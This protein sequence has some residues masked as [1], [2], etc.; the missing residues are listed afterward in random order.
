M[1]ATV[2]NKALYEEIMEKA[3]RIGEVA[4]IEALEAD[5]NSTISQR[6]AD[7]IRDENIHRLILPKE[8]GYPQLDWRTFVD[9]V[10]TVGYYNLSASWLTYFFSAHNAWVCYY[11]K[12]I[13][14][15]VINQGGFVA[16]VFAP[17]GKVEPVEGGFIV[18]GKYNF[19]S[20]INYCDW[21]GVGAMMQFEDSDRP[22]RVGILLKVSDLTIEKTWNSLGLRGSGSNTLIVDEVFVKPEAIL[23]FNK[24]IEKS[25]PPYENFDQDYLYYNTPFYPGFYVGFAAMAVGGAKR[26]LDEFEKHTAGRIRFSG[27]NEKDSPASQRVLAELKLEML[28]ANTLLTEYINM[29]ENDKG[30]PYEGPK[31]KAIRAAIIDKSANIGVKALLTLGG[32]ALLKG[33]PVELFTRDLIA[34]ATHITSLYEDGI[35]GYGK[36]LFG[37][38]TNIQG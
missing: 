24:I 20:G 3:R 28:S 2:E 5:E 25:Q 12:H 16:D 38:K 32:H 29:M 6:V 30:G 18:S 27:I 21:V 22:E 7:L 1:V 10:S 17:I 31:Y 4:E 19:V 11:P 13:R 8:F 23:R 14:D 9:M 26:V 34:I 15:E 37:V 33:H 35:L 36:H